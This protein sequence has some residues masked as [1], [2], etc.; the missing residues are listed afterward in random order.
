MLIA[1][2]IAKCLRHMI[3]AD[4]HHA[5]SQRAAERAGRV[6]AEQS[7]RSRHLQA[8]PEP[9]PKEPLLSAGASEAATDV[10]TSSV[11]RK[12]ETSSASSSKP[13]AVSSKPSSL[14]LPFTPIG[15]ATSCFTQRYV[16]TIRSC[17]MLLR[18][19]NSRH[20]Q[21]GKERGGGREQRVLR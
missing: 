14:T 4:L 20:K 1:D 5:T 7:L 3:Q 17:A 13:A 10:N 18:S 6:R 15:F 12:D 9:E 19:G 11:H 2:S 21:R 16:G 8:A